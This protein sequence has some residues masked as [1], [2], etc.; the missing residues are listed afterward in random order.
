MQKNVFIISGPAGVG[1]STTA[2]KLAKVLS[3]SAYISGDYI[4][5]MHINGRQK[6]WLS[7]EENTLIWKNILSLTKNF[8]NSGCDVVIDYVTFP[9]EVRWLK[10]GLKEEDICLKYIVLWTDIETLIERDN[11]RKPEHRMG[12]RCL[13]LMDEYRD[14]SIEEKQFL[15]TSKVLIEE[16]DL[17]LN[18]I[19][20]SD[21][22]KVN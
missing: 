6:P 7:E 19:I 21:K 22:Y 20:S 10:E 9:N 2:I 17:V 5:H 14:S 15:D 8:I 16:M 3:N 11:L 18:N 13:V 12:E 4:S 1:K